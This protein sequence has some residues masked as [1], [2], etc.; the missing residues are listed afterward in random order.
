MTLLS[1][2]VPVMV[3]PEGILQHMA[4]RSRFGLKAGLHPGHARQSAPGHYT[5]EHWPAYVSQDK[6]YPG[7]E[8]AS[9]DHDGIGKMV[10]ADLGA[11]A[12]AGAAGAAAGCAGADGWAAGAGAAA[13]RDAWLAAIGRYSPRNALLWFWPSILAEL[14]FF[15]PTVSHP[16]SAQRQLS[17]VSPHGRFHARSARLV[18][19][20]HEPRCRLQFVS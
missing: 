9:N 5:G 17:H 6:W 15:L 7:F 12:E 16:S 13:G 3:L 10:N 8:E 2:M 11:G 14:L 20:T 18:V 19:K 4:V 1:F